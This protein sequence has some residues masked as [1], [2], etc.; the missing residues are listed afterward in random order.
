M[1]IHTSH[2]KYQPSEEVRCPDFW[3]KE[4][5][6]IHVH[7]PWESCWFLECYTVY[8]QCRKWEV[9]R[10]EGRERERER[11]GQGRTNCIESFEQPQQP[12]QRELGEEDPFSYKASPGPT[13]AHAMT[14]RTSTVTIH[15][16]S[17]TLSDKS[18]HTSTVFIICIPSSNKLSVH[19]HRSLALQPSHA[20]IRGCTVN[21]N[22][23][24]RQVKVQPTQKYTHQGF[25]WAENF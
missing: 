12:V 24:K 6:H 16:A 13:I 8:Y 5:P 25:I 19:K 14:G 23:Y 21:A 3:G 9:G 4:E 1:N 17:Y 10:S 11:G 18:T 20:C 22:H 7:R 2:I 15:V